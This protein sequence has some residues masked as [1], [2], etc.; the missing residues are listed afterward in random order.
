MSEAESKRE[1]LKDKV[2]GLV[3]EFV[4]NENNLSLYEINC[5]IDDAKNIL[6]ATPISFSLKG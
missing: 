4:S 3:K 6:Q 5:A 1:L 2:V